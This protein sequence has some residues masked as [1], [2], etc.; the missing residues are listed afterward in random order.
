MGLLLASCAQVPIKDETWDISLGI[1]GAAEFHT[2]S[3]ESRDLDLNAWA[4][5]WDDLTNPQGPMACTRTATL[6]E[7]KAEVEKLCSFAKICNVELKTAISSL[8]T[9]VNTVVE[10]AKNLS[11]APQTKKDSK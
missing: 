1:T 7:I 3:T 2:L 6:A 4:A 9:R 8:S 10:K 5:L 11:V